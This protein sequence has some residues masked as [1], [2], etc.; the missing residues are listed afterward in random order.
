MEWDQGE[1]APSPV[2]YLESAMSEE[3]A[4]GLYRLEIPL[5]GNP[6]KSM[7]SYVIKGPGRNLIIDTGLDIKVCRDAMHIALKEIGI[8]ISKTDFFITHFH[9]DHSGLVSSLAADTSMVFFSKTDAEFIARIGVRERYTQYADMMGFPDDE[10]KSALQNHPGFSHGGS[11]IRELTLLK[12]G[13]VV[14]AGGY[15]FRCV[16]TPGHT[17]GHLCLYEP[18]MKFLVAG[19]HILSEITPNIQL[20]SDT[21]DPLKKYLN[22][23]EKVSRLD[24]ELVLPGHRSLFTN[25]K[26]RI[27]ELKE[28]YKRRLDEVLHI[29]REGSKNAYQVAMRM[30]WDIECPSWEQFPAAQK[31]FATGEAIAHLRFLEGEHKIRRDIQN[32]KVFFA[33]N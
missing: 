31:W 11:R 14:S 26:E 8:D 23:L 20:W 30:T 2:L 6:L 24:V 27:Q 22:S 5:P 17:L 3:I 7:N 16:E 18:R 10:L 4:R 25:C 13:D 32:G 21:D 29:L 12:E 19:D 15:D 28:H 1:K 9:A 33:L